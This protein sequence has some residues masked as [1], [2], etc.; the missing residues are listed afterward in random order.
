MRDANKTITWEAPL[1]IQHTT[2]P[3]SRTT[4]L[5]Q[6]YN[7]GRFLPNVNDCQISCES[8][9]L[10]VIHTEE[11]DDRRSTS[12][13]AC[14]FLSLAHER[15]RA[16]RE[17]GEPNR[18][19]NPS[20]ERETDVSVCYETLI[21][22]ILTAKYGLS[23]NYTFAFIHV[24]LNDHMTTASLVMLVKCQLWWTWACPVWSTAVYLLRYAC[25]RM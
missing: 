6:Q 22:H 21:K 5:S 13:A 18:S 16:N 2:N 23:R 11:H 9:V 20:V 4:W 1:N 12:H 15:D 25:T 8:T 19:V 17:R 24:T 14:S 10:K 7:E 3:I